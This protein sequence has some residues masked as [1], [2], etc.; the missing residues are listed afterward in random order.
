MKQTLWDAVAGID[1]RYILEAAEVRRQSVRK[2]EGPETGSE[3]LRATTRRWS[4][5]RAAVIALCLGLSAAGVALLLRLAPWS[6]ADPTPG[7]AIPPVVSTGETDR[8][9]RGGEPTDAALEAEIQA[10]LE[11][12]Q[13]KQLWAADFFLETRQELPVLQYSA[14]PDLTAC[15]PELLELLL[16][17]AAISKK[18]VSPDGTVQ[19]RLKQG[20]TEIICN[21]Y[22]G[23]I[24]ING[25]TSGQAAELFPKAEAWFAE[26][27]GL[28]LREWEGS[29]RLG[30]AYRAAVGTVDGVPIGP[31]SCDSFGTNR[32][33]QGHGVWLNNTGVEL[34]GPILVGEELR[35]VKLFDSFSPEELRM[36]TEFN[37]NPDEPVIEVYRSC[38]LCYLIH[39]QKGQ[40]LPVWWVRGTRYDYES[41][42]ETPFEM[43]FDAETGGMY[44][45]GGY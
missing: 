26:K 40:L 29:F 42:T 43:V 9:T 16:P 24:S 31:L 44:D 6:S 19:V 13:P 15:Y 21:V 27:T 14:A 23:M 1:E 35:T 41:G 34:L 11:A 37:F 32:L 2:K 3:K 18:K 10:A 20:R 4:W 36:T 17:D 28:E 5:G 25:V 8:E 12:K 7:T 39:E 38:E 22:T 45:F 33:D 30:S